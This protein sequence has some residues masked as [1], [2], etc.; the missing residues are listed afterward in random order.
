MFENRALRRI[1]GP[2][3][4]EVTGKWRKLLDEEL[5]DLYCSLN[6]VRVII[7]PIMR[8]SGHVARM[9]KR[10]IS[11]TILVGKPEQKRPRH[12]WEDNIKMDLQEMEWGWAWT[13]LFCLR[14]GTGGRLL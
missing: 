10:R 8:R 7:L 3:T 1:F 5:N 14:I 9:E 4:D 13:E 2:K 11:Y 12:R 6:I